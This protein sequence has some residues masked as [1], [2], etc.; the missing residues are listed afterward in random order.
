M[1]LREMK[2]VDIRSVNVNELVELS[3][4][5]TDPG[6]IKFVR[7]KNYINQIKNPYCFRIGETAI[8]TSY[9]KTGPTI[10]EL[11][12]NIITRLLEHE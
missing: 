7:I 8:K 12:A 10:E 9:A 4:V 2:D 1:T 11:L 6:L 3:T 5:H